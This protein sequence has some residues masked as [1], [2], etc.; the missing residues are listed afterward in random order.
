MKDIINEIDSRIKS[1]LF[2]YFMFSLIAINWAPLFYL[3]MDAGPVSERIKYF[4]QGTDSFSLFLYPLLVASVYSIGYPWLHYL[5]IFL[6]TKPTELKNSLQAESEHKLLTKKQ[7]LE[8]ARSEI[9][10]SAEK[11]LI[12]RAKRDVELSEIDDEKV[13]G[14]LES[15]IVQLRKE[16]DKMRVDTFQSLGTKQSSLTKEQEEIIRLITAQGGS[17]NEVEIINNSNYD[18]VKTEYYLEDLENKEYLS[19]DYKASPISAYVYS[20]TTKSKKIMV[21]QGVAK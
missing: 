18:K 7:E 14:E 2:G 17:M 5:F 6:G 21:E 4:R 8:D 9:L 3:I 11:E 12:E 20:L 1:P 10:K 16:R 13:R 15:E 19:K